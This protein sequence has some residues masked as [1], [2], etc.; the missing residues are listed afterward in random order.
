LQTERSREAGVG[1]VW[2][3]WPFASAQRTPCVPEIGARKR[4][5]ETSL[6]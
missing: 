6:T 1:T 5:P 2:P 3:E 4:W